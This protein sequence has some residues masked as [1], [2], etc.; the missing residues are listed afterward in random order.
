MNRWL[1]QVSGAI[2]LSSTLLYGIVGFVKLMKVVDDVHAPMGI[3]VTV[4]SL[5][6]A[7]SGYMA[8]S[9]LDK[10]TDNQSRMLNS[11]N[12]HRVSVALFFKFNLFHFYRHWLI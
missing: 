12:I 6:L 1:H 4:L 11:R 3:A 2:V 9:S 5:I 7:I 8:W 10:S